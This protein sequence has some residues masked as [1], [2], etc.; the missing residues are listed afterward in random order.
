M[1][2]EAKILLGRG[3]FSIYALRLPLTEM[4]LQSKINRQ[5][6]DRSGVVSAT[7]QVQ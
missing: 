3:N 5:K 1:L 6:V 7:V 4:N 2:G